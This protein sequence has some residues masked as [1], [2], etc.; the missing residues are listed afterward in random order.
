MSEVEADKKLK[1][2]ERRR[3]RAGK[4]NG[5]PGFVAWEIEEG[6]VGKELRVKGSL[7]F[8]GGKA[9][10]ANAREEP[11]LPSWRPRS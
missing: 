2:G 11:E 6:K 4:R 5:G 8:Q 3:K 1:G 7:S 9:S 10:L